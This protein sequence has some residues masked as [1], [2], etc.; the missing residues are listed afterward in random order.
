MKVIRTHL[1]KENDVMICVGELLTDVADPLS[2]ILADY[3]REH[4]PEMLHRLI[5]NLVN[6]I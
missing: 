1:L 3:R 2:F 4:T 5:V 6:L